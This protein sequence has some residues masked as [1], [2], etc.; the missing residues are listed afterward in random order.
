[1]CVEAGVR[2]IEHGNLLDADTAKAMAAA[3]TYLVPTLVTYEKLHAEGDRHGI[4]KDNLDKLAA[5]IDAGVESIRHARAAGVAIGSGSDL[6][7]PMRRYQGAEIGLQARALGALGAITAATRTNAELIGVAGEVGTIEEGKLADLV[8]VRGDVLAD[9]D[10]I[11]DPAH[12]VLVMKG[13]ETHIL[14]AD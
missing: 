3:G 10:L 5:I 6:L 12:L 9:P 1:V 13:G 7:G 4:P 2:S 11:G 14:R 8:A